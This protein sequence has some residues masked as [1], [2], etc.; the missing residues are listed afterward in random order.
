MSVM[1]ARSRAAAMARSAIAPAVARDADSFW[2]I[3]AGNQNL[4]IRAKV[5]RA[6]QRDV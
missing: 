1:M 3:S 2:L 5:A 6:T 4:V